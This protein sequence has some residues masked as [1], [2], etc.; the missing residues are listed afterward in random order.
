[1]NSNSIYVNGIVLQ[2]EDI[3]LYNLPMLK[4]DLRE[5]ICFCGDK[6]VK[7]TSADQKPH[8]C[9][10]SSNRMAH[11]L[12]NDYSNDDLLIVTP[13]EVC[14]MSQVPKVTLNAKSVT[15]VVNQYEYDASRHEGMHIIQWPEFW[16]AGQSVHE[17]YLQKRNIDHWMPAKLFTCYNMKVRPHRTALYQSFLNAGTITPNGDRLDSDLAWYSYINMGFRLDE[18]EEFVYN[19]EDDDPHFSYSYNAG[20][21]MQGERGHHNRFTIDSEYYYCGLF[22]VVCETEPEG[23]VRWTEKTVRPLMAEKPFLIMG[24]IGINT[25]LQDLG[26]KL[27]PCFDYSFDHEPDMEKRAVG[28]VQQVTQYTNADI[29]MLKDQ[30]REIAHYNRQRAIEIGLTHEIPSIMSDLTD[31]WSYQYFMKHRKR[32]DENCN[33]G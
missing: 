12:K 16:F 18:G 8:S 14:I 25:K 27:Y 1:M 7:R 24:S 30:C 33:R 20:V 29:P 4:K 31:S 26:F 23:Y 17:K 21:F 28:I 9:V 32:L 19:P 13:E 22:D 11:I 3:P 15:L 2:D 5:I 10:L 6:E